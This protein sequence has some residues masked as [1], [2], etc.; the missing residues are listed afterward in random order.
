MARRIFLKTRREVV[1]WRASQ[2]SEKPRHPCAGASRSTPVATRDRPG[3]LD[4]AAGTQHH[5]L[6]DGRHPQQPIL[7]GVLLEPHGV[8][9]GLRADAPDQRARLG[10]DHDIGRLRAAVRT[11]G[12]HWAPATSAESM[13]SVTC[14]TATGNGTAAPLWWSSNSRKRTSFTASLLPNTASSRVLASTVM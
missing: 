3:D 10:V 5:A 8:N 12:Q 7:A 9:G 4:Q 14:S 1:E 11:R 6:R 2:G 13:A